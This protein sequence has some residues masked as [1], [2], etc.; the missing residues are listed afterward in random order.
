MRALVIRALRHEISTWCSLGRWVARRPDVGPGGTPFA[1]R[2]PIVAPIVVLTVVSVIEV[3]AVDM[4]LAPWPV[5]RRILLVLGIW[6]ALFMLGLLAS[7]TVRPHVVAPSGLRI[8]HGASLDVHVPWDAVASAGRLRRSGDGRTVQ[9]VGDAL[10]VL[11]SG[12]TTG[13]VTL[14]RPV[15]AT[16]RGTRAEVT[17]LRFHADDAAGMVAAIRARMSAATASSA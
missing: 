7:V 15:P 14:H 4:V 9:L 8:R 1:Y 2:G 13:V 10:H 5:P 16:I 3:V 11:V 6:G 17:E 12:Q